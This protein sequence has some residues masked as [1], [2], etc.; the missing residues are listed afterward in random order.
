MKLDDNQLAL[1]P[2]QVTLD[3]LL[4]KYAKGDETSVEDVRR[5][6][7]RALAAV[8]KDPARWEPVFFEA[9]DNGFIPGGRINSAAGTQLQATLINCFVQPVGD[10]VS[11]TVDGKPGIYVALHGGG[12]DH[13]P[14]RRRGLR[15][16]RDPPQGRAGARHREHGERAGVLHAGVRQELRDGGIRRLAPRR[17]DGHP[18]LRPSRHRGLHPRQGPRRPQ[19]LQRERRRDRRLHARGR[20]RRRLGARAQGA[21]RR[22]TSRAQPRA[23]RRRAVGLSHGQGARSVAADH[24]VHL[25][26]RRAGRV[27]RR[28]RQRGQQSLLLRD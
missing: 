1:P 17:A 11:E 26:S 4:E 28:P 25:R 24:G 8:E 23:A 9:L 14:R 20:G 22:R 7:A 19:E 16:F 2:Q 13:A 12:R 5:R 18:A 6:V 15:F 27:L 3:V 21:A 10:S